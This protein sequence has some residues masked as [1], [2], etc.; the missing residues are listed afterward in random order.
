LLTITVKSVV[1]GW[2]RVAFLSYDVLVA[3]TGKQGLDLIG[4]TWFH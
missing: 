3:Y 1:P 4:S 2:Q